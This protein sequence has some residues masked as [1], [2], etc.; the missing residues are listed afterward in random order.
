MLLACFS[1]HYWVC[2]CRV[3]NG[4]LEASGKRQMSEP[5]ASTLGAIM[6]KGGKNE[7][8]SF[9]QNKKIPNSKYFLFF[10][11]RGYGS[12]SYYPAAGA[13]SSYHY[14]S[15]YGG[16]YSPTFGRSYHHSGGATGYGSYAGGGSG[17]YPSGGAGGSMLPYR[18]WK[19]S[20]ALDSAHLGGTAGD[21]L[22][23]P[24]IGYRG[25][26]GY[27]A[28][29]DDYYSGAPPPRP[30]SSMDFVQYERDQLRR[31]Q[32]QHHEDYYHGRSASAA[33]AVP[34]NSSQWDTGGGGGGRDAWG[35]WRGEMGPSR[36]ARKKKDTMQQRH[37]PFH[38][39]PCLEHYTVQPMIERPPGNKGGKAGKGSRRAVNSH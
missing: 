18:R 22:H 5:H 2:G 13:A 8:A 32:Q 28:A 36:R 38:S 29:A 12:R 14:P 37:K 9:S 4:G 35:R 19:S 20:G 33:A 25:S 7:A 21:Y 24:A 34:Y 10:L 11:F 16:T 23:Q 30:Q 27:G 15:G 39:P 1:R 26:G 3:E 6:E 17:Y 31:R